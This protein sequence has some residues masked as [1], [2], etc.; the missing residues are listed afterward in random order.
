VV[1]KPVWDNVVAKAAQESSE[2]SAVKYIM[3]SVR[4]LSLSYE[5]AI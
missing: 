5:E 2:L 4:F 3:S 1:A